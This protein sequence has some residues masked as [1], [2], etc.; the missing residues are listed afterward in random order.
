MFTCPRWASRALVRTSWRTSSCDRTSRYL[1]TVQCRLIYVLLVARRSSCSALQRAVSILARRAAW[2]A[3][4]CAAIARSR[5]EGL[6]TSRE[7][8]GRLTTSSVPRPRLSST[9]TSTADILAGSRGRRRDPAEVGGQRDLDFRPPQPQPDRRDLP[10]SQPQPGRGPQPHCL[11]S[12]QRVMLVPPVFARKQ[13]G[14]GAKDEEKSAMRQPT[15]C[16]QPARISGRARCAHLVVVP[17]FRARRRVLASTL[18]VFP[19]ARCKKFDLRD[20]RC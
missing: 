9:R 2:V 10:P 1:P 13:H 12:S 18:L 19:R 3:I 14:N 7:V 11:H 6:A 4:R 15:S 17:A 20:R 8:P 16:D 5:S